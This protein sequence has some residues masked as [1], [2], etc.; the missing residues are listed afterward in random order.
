MANTQNQEP[1]LS[2]GLEVSFSLLHDPHF[3]TIYTR[4]PGRGS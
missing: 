3:I 2:D 1:R 4:T